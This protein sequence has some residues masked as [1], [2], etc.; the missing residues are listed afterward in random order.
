MFKFPEKWTHQQQQR[1]EMMFA[2]YPDLKAAYTLSQHLRTIFN[3]RSIKSAA[4][5]NLARWYNNVADAHFRSFNTIV[6]TVYEHHEEILNYFDNFS[7]NASAESINSKIKAFR[8]KLHGVT[9]K[10][11]FIF[12][13]CNLYA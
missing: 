11:F 6:A 2:L 8:A 4:R 5:L 3:K 7:T 10:K 1:A 12:R 13:L 9:D